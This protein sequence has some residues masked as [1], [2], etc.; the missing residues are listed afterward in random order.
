[1]AHAPT[2][3]FDS[4]EFVLSIIFSSCALDE[5][6]ANHRSVFIIISSSLFGL[7]GFFSFDIFETQVLCLGL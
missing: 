3:T 5:E 7:F 2:F 4:F 1:M 6:C